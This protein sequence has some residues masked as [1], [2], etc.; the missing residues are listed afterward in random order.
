MAEIY[1]GCTI[2]S[3]VGRCLFNTVVDDAANGWTVTKT[4]DYEN[5]THTYSKAVIINGQNY[6]LESEW[7]AESFSKN[8][9]HYW[10]N[11]TV[12]RLWQGDTLIVTNAASDCNNLQ[13]ACFES[14]YIATPPSARIESN[15]LTDITAKVDQI[16]RYVSYTD[17]R[18]TLFE[19]AVQTTLNLPQSPDYLDNATPRTYGCCLL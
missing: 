1:E 16:M 11:T 2:N 17:P 10:M 14:D 15:P 4:G 7:V 19:Q 8:N 6:R 18:V 13:T 3:L 12:N 9:T 5:H